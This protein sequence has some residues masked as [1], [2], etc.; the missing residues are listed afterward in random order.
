MSQLKFKK[1]RARSEEAKKL[2]STHILRKCRELIERGGTDWTMD[3]LAI[4][5][6]LAKGTLYLYFKNKQEVL[7]ALS[8]EALILWLDKAESSKGEKALCIAK[9]FEEAFLFSSPPM[10]ASLV[11]IDRLAL[12]VGTKEKAIQAY[13]LLLGLHLSGQ[14]TL[15]TDALRTLLFEGKQA[16][17]DVQYHFLGSY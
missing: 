8:N 5:C 11:T 13:A 12:L 17:P 14:L 1:R 6:R 3:E 2:R 10:K 15:A 7:T 4:F 9:S 16:K